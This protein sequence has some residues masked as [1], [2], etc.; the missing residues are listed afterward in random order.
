[1]LLHNGVVGSGRVV[2]MGSWELSD[3]EKE[4]EEENKEVFFSVV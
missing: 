2:R 4:E 3:E 1:M